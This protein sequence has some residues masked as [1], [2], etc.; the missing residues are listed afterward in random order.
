MRQSSTTQK[1]RRHLVCL[2]KNDNEKE[3]KQSQ[4]LVL[5]T[6]SDLFNECSTDSDEKRPISIAAVVCYSNGTVSSQ[7][8]GKLDRILI[9]GALTDLVNQIFFEC[10]QR[11]INDKVEETVKALHLASLPPD[12]KIN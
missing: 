3:Q 1:R 8:A 11:E 5:D 10:K 4:V 12:I 7:M 2:M 6:L 9:T